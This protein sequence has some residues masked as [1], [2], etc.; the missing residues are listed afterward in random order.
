[1]KQFEDPF[2]W[3]KRKMQS[4]G[5]AAILG[6]KAFWIAVGIL[7]G[8]MVAGQMLTWLIHLIKR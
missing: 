7:G 6:S 3:Q 8:I 1:M 2:Y 4:D 5:V